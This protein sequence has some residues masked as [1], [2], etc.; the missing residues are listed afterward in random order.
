LVGDVVDRPYHLPASSNIFGTVSITQAPSNQTDNIHFL[1]CDPDNYQQ[2]I[3]GTQTSSLYSA[4]RKGLV[5][6]TFTTNKSGVYHF[7]FD[8]RGFLYKK[9]V[10][11]TVSYNEVTTSQVPD[12]RVA[13]V[14]W[15]LIIGGGLI[16]V[17]GLVKKP[18]VPWA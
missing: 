11:L 2:C 1:V 8:N 6:Y 4:D 13:Y 12:T 18:P 3:A 7:V 14:A 10:V 15:P 17:Y 16:L 5:N 9:Y